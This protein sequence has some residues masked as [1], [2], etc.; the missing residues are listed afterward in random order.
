MQTHDEA[1]AAMSDVGKWQNANCETCGGPVR[2]RWTNLRAVADTGDER[3]AGKEIEHIK[4]RLP[5]CKPLG[6]TEIHIWTQG[7]PAAGIDG[8]SAMLC[9][10]LDMTREDRE[11]FR[12]RLA[13]FFAETWDMGGVRVMFEEEAYE[14]GPEEQV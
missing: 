4:H 13:E 8:N 5:Y 11:A 12:R 2:W 6:E 1:I 14:A 3:V 9:I 7:D 10:D